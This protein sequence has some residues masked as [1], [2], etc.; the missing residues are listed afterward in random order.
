MTRKG[1]KLCRNIN[2]KGNYERKTVPHSLR[3]AWS[4]ESEHHIGAIP[5]PP[6]QNSRN[7]DQLI[8]QSFGQ[9]LFISRVNR[10]S[11]SLV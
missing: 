9:A 8:F 6:M 10:P 3:Q 7:E 5:G 1:K 4:R 11:I 2:S